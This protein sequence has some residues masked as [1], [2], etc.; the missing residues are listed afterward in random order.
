M[1]L[2]YYV[3]AD[4][5]CP[6]ELWFEGLDRMAATKVVVALARLELGNFSNVKSVGEGV[7]E[8]RIDW[9]AGIGCISAGAVKNWWFCSLVEPKPA[10]I[11]TSGW[12]TASGRITE[13]G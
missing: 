13:E 7:L 12:R 4:G 8:Y 6:F 1:E 3:A 11:G 9:G 10:R 5:R 2:Q